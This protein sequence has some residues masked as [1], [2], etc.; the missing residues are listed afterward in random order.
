MQTGIERVNKEP[1][2][3]TWV[4]TKTEWPA[5]MKGKNCKSDESPQQKAFDYSR[6]HSDMPVWALQLSESNYSYICQP[7]FNFLTEYTTKKRN[8][9]FYYEVIREDKPVNFYMD[10][11]LK[12][13][14]SPKHLLPSPRD[15]EL[16]TELKKIVEKVMLDY[17][18]SGPNFLKKLPSDITCIELDASNSQKISKH[19]I[20]RVD[21][22]KLQDYRVAKLLYHRIMKEIPKESVLWIED[23]EGKV[24]SFIDGS[25]YSRNRQFRLYQSTKITTPYRW[26]SLPGLDEPG[27]LPNPI[28]FTRTLVQWFADG[29]YAIVSSG[30]EELQKTVSVD[31]GTV[32]ETD[33]ARDFFPESDKD[34]DTIV[35]KLS[36]VVGGNVKGKLLYGN[37]VICYNN[38]KRTHCS[39]AGH[40]HKHNHT[41]WLLNMETKTYKARCNSIRCKGKYGTEISIPSSYFPIIH[42]YLVQQRPKQLMNMWSLRESEDFTLTE[43]K[44]SRFPLLMPFIPSNGTSTN[45]MEAHLRMKIRDEGKWNQ[46]IHIFQCNKTEWRD[47]MNWNMIVY[48]P[49]NFTP[50]PNKV[51]VVAYQIYDA[52]WS[53]VILGWT[54]CSA[55]PRFLSVSELEVT[56]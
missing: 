14:V 47:A 42:D 39:I 15:A 23:T 19:F 46:L 56:G 52:P 2:E 12:R 7:Y 16:V 37:T 22:V 21:G 35:Q 44:M 53:F 54:A 34:R 9:R 30:L 8:Q 13:A 41:G 36:S 4:A 49:A 55:E 20:V 51:L 1:N 28:M 38:L 26:L 11:E 10:C 45:K 50:A 33:N 18:N 43:Q 24:H 5:F 17:L 29:K 6:A 31:S 25:V 27:D 3:Q 32:E 40:T 48:L